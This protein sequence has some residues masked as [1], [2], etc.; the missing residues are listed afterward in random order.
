M[1]SIK[2][3]I[4]GLAILVLTMFVGVYGISTLYGESPMYDDYCPTNLINQSVCQAEGGAWVDNSRL[5][6]D[7]GGNVKPVAVE[8]GYCQYDYTPCQDDFEAAQKVYYKK[9]FL[10]SLPLGILLIFLGAGVFGL[11]SVGAG[12]MIGGVGLMVYGTGA[13][14]RF[15]DDWMKFVL[16]LVGLI[17][18]IV[19][20]YWFNSG[21][22][23]F[24]KRF[25][26]G[27]K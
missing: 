4:F 16:S 27:K 13:Y 14:W 23:N 26:K 1:V 10:T 3:I 12:L 6:Q 19:F 17:L 21:H 5:A 18:L 25:F 15:T 22:K 9:V 8:G 11:E 20:A 7:N 2:N 24:W